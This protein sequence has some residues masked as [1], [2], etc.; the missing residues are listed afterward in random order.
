M[1]QVKRLVRLAERAAANRGLPM[2]YDGAAALL[3]ISGDGM[4][5]GL[6]NLA[7][8]VGGLPRQQW[9]AA[10]AAHFAQMAPGG[11]P[12]AVPQDLENQLYLRLTE[13]C[14]VPAEWAGRVPEFV[15]GLLIAPATY[16]GR[17]VA[18][19]FD[20]DSLG[21]PWPEVNRIG[22][23]NLRRL[24]DTV[25]YV[26]APGAEFAMI[27]GGMFTASRALVLDTVLRESLHVENPEFGCL[28]AMPARDMLLVHVLRDSTV[29]H[30][31]GAMMRV[32]T[33]FYAESPG[34]VSPHVY[35]VADN[36]WHQMTDYSGG[37]FDLKSTAAFSEAVSRAEAK[38][39]RELPT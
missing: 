6:T 33:C 2:R 35:F 5:A 22:L 38:A 27:T 26:R 21:L 24:R 20:L 23:A 17:A 15:P 13:A 11:R 9:R 39:P 30:A 4:I 10:V 36:E 1:T 34:P 25:E 7:R 8:T 32:A 19:H 12:P 3:P 28:V 31:F 14:T 37:T 29:I 18:M 16:V